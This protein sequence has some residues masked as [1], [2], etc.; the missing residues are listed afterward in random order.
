MLFR[1]VL[2]AI[3]LLDRKK[4][5]MKK[6]TLDE[7][8]RLCLKQWRWIIKEVKAKDF[9][10]AVELKKEWCEQHG[11]TEIES[12]CFFCEYCSNYSTTK[13]SCSNCPAREIDPKFR[14]KNPAYHYYLHPIEFYNKIV[15]LN[16]RRLEAQ[17]VK[18]QNH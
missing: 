1:F 4:V 14:C 18:G 8:W 13:P 2:D 7:S 3:I 10:C 12:N 16:K 6:I 11:F 9:K 15:Q 5:K 17:N